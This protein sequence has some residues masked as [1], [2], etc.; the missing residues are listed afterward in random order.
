MVLICFYVSVYLMDANTK[1]MEESNSNKS[2]IPS[3]DEKSRTLTDAVD[4]SDTLLLEETLMMNPII[5]TNTCGSTEDTKMM[6]SIVDE[7]IIAK[8]VPDELFP[9]TRVFSSVLLDS[10]SAK[11]KQSEISSPN[12]RQ[13]IDKDFPSTRVFPGVLFDSESTKEN[14]TNNSVVTETT[15]SSNDVKKDMFVIQDALLFCPMGGTI[16]LNE[17]LHQ[18]IFASKQETDRLK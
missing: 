4:R 7:Q 11:E 18:G 5:L 13:E 12:K 10:E 1:M 6:E 9:S 3:T 8:N 16:V 14:Q 2:I 17:V 15:A